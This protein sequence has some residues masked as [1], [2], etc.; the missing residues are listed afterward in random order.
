MSF[1]KKNCHCQFLNNYHKHYTCNNS[2]YDI[3]VYREIFNHYSSM[4]VMPISAWNLLWHSKLHKCLSHL[5]QPCIVSFLFLAPCFGQYLQVDFF[6]F[7]RINLCKF[8]L[9]MFIGKTTK[10]G[11]LLLTKEKPFTNCE[12]RFTLKSSWVYLFFLLSTWLK[13]S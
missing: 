6:F 8:G 4:T 12:T 7:N 2:D 3:H 5:L 1:L 9:L 11:V 13:W 10:G